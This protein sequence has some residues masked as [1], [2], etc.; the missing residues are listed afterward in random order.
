ML[1]R[2]SLNP[3]VIEGSDVFQFIT[4]GDSVN[5][6]L[7][8]D[9]TEVVKHLYKLTGLPTGAVKEIIWTSEYRQVSVLMLLLVDLFMI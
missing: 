6:E 8:K 5:H 1:F 4:R 3:D 7:L 2:L 9:P